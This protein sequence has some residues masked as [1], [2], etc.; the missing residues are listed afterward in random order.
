[1]G[2]PGMGIDELKNLV[3]ESLLTGL[4]TLIRLNLGPCLGEARREGGLLG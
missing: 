4:V 1:M 3:P 2:I